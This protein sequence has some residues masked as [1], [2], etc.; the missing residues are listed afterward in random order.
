MNRG[1]GEARLALPSASAWCDCQDVQAEDIVSG[2]VPDPHSPAVAVPEVHFGLLQQPSRSSHSFALYSPAKRL[3][4]RDGRHRITIN[5]RRRGS[6]TFNP[7]S[8]TKQIDKS[9]P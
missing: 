1:G 2:F 3:G 7:F 4:T 9:S 5:G 8:I 6:A